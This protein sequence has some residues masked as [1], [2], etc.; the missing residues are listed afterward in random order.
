ME[1]QILYMIEGEFYTIICTQT[2]WNGKKNLAISKTL[3]SH[4]RILLWSYHAQSST[5]ILCS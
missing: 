3:H 1:T 2:D 5:Y 4:E